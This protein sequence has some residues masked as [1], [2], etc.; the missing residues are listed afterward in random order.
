MAFGL[1]VAPLSAMPEHRLVD[2]LDSI[3]AV[4][5]LWSTRSLARAEV[6]GMLVSG[7][8]AHHEAA[9]VL[10]EGLARGVLREEG[11]NVVLGSEPTD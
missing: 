9:H 3:A 4:L 1:S 10:S 6:L 5:R 2:Y 7:G 8:L 11:D